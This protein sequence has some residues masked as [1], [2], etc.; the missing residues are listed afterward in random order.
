MYVKFL[1]PSSGI[2]GLFSSVAFLVPL[3]QA[4]KCDEQISTRQILQ[5]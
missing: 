5:Y 4:G 2:K 1:E 3:G